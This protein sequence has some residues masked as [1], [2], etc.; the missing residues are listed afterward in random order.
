MI[1][2]VEDFKVF[3]LNPEVA[4]E[5]VDAWDNE[6]EDKNIVDFLVA[7]DKHH[8]LEKVAPGDTGIYI[9]SD[10]VGRFQMA[11][12][13]GLP[14]KDQDLL[15]AKLLFG[16]NEKEPGVYYL[17]EN[18]K[19]NSLTVSQA[20]DPRIWNYISLYILH[21]YVMERWG[22]TRK[23]S[24]VILRSTTLNSTSRHGILRLYWS[25]FLCADCKRENMLELLDQMWFSEDF[26]TQILERST[27]SMQL[28]VQYLLEFCSNKERHDLLFN[29][30]SIEGYKN[31]R[32]FLKLFLADSFVFSMPNL[33]KSEIDRLLEESL[34]ACVIEN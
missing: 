32:K 33:S 10:V 1:K 26:M 16:E 28:Q 12:F 27:A 11:E 9:D 2:K 3:A 7:Y 24:R 34:D 31:Y 17:D 5:I 18:G 19:K 22:E 6:F 23:I 13:S 4:A 8:H 25:A 30:D 20:T 21:D 14:P 29:K 15:Y